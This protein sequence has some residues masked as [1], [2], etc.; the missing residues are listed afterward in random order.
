MI[1]NFNIDIKCD[2]CG[3]FLDADFYRKN[4]LL[5]IAVC[6][7]CLNIKNNI[8]K[9]LENQI[10]ELTDKLNENGK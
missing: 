2:K 6:E 10:K 3:Q 1:F 4:K 7:H 9:K 5:K 8:I